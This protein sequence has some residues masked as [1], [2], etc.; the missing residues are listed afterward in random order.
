MVLDMSETYT[1]LFESI[2][3]SS[4]WLEDDQ[5][6]RVWV[7]MLALADRN[8]YVGASVGGLA[9][10]AR[11]S[12]EKT[13]EALAK[14]LAPDPDSRSKEFEG[15]RIEVADRGWHILNYER[16]RDMRDEEA[17]KEY[18]RNRKKEQR[19]ATKEKSR[20]VQACPAMSPAVTTRHEKSAQAEAEAEADPKREKAP[21]APRAPRRKILT[22]DEIRAF[23]P[24]PAD[25]ERAKASGLVLEDVLQAWRNN[26]ISKGFRLVDAG[27]DFETWLAREIRFAKRDKEQGREPPGLREHRA[28]GGRGDEGPAP[29]R[30][31]HR[32]LANKAP[33]RLPAAEAL[34]LAGGAIASLVKVT[35]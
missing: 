13:E 23:V 29:P 19:A 27:P 14:F 12:K 30:P 17:R 6:L 16:F 28:T 31:E 5:T 22:P 3:R 34:K 8:G 10:Q 7:T 32:Q 18:E 24:P 15:R 4:I 26:R 25:Q 20:T 35:P 21:P 11:V 1:K 9:A 2:T 33:A